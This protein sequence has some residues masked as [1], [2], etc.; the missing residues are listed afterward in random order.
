MSLAHITQKVPT[1]FS[2]KFKNSIFLPRIFTTILARPYNGQKH[3]SHQKSLQKQ[4]TISTLK[5]MMDGPYPH[6][7]PL[8]H[9][10]LNPPQSP[11]PPN[12]PPTPSPVPPIKPNHVPFSASGVPVTH[13]VTSFSTPW[14]L[15]DKNS[16]VLNMHTSTVKHVFST[17]RTT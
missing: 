8:L 9:L 4:S 3:V 1:K 2:P 13:S 5:S 6:P 14:S 11:N 12:Y 16:K 7:T 15:A 17:V 10:P